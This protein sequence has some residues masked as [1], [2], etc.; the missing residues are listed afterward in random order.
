MYLHHYLASLLYSICVST[1]QHNRDHFPISTVPTQEE[2][3]DAAR[4]MFRL[5]FGISSTNTKEYREFCVLIV[6]Y[7]APSS[8]AKTSTTPGFA[9]QF[10]HSPSVHD[11]T[12]SST[13]SRRSSDGRII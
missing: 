7:I 13:I 6:N 12:Y 11:S 5:I 3:K 9:L 10:H 4:N 2:A 1:E 8:L